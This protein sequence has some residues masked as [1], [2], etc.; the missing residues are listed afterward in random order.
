MSV[1]K[2]ATLN[3]IQNGLFFFLTFLKVYREKDRKKTHPLL[4]ELSLDDELMGD[5]SDVFGIIQI[6]L[7]ELIYLM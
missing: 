5:S 3:Y 4:A 7:N 2:N 6:H 1:K